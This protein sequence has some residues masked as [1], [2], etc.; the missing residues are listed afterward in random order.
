MSWKAEG[1]SSVSPY[2][3]VQDAE[4]AL[5]FMEGVFDAR[6]IQGVGDTNVFGS[7]YAMRIWLD[8]EKLAAHDLTVQDVDA[9][10]ALGQLVGDLAGAVG[11]VV[12]DDE[13]VR[14]R[15]SGMDALE[16]PGK[17]L[18]LVVS[19]QEHE[20]AIDRGALLRRGQRGHG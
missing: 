3:I 5:A 11:R 2:L 16:D 12:I 9:G 1:Y 7:Q 10:V 15:N 14:M 8:P 6:R 18:A 13:D 17:V 19:R 4:R 20:H